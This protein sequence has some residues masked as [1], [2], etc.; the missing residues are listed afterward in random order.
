MYIFYIILLDHFIIILLDY[1]IIFL[2]GR[3]II[4][5]LG[6]IIIILLGCFRHDL[7]RSLMN[8][9]LIIKLFI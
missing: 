1:F 8:N 2:L 7:N 5:L 6:R 4:S 3:F 9:I